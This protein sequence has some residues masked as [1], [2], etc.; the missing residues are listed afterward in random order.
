MKFYV[1]L[2]DTEW[3]ENLRSLQPDEVNFWKP[4]G[5]AFKALEPGAPFLF[6]LRRARYIV[7]GGYFI[8]FTQLPVEITW[9]IFGQKNGLPDYESFRAAIQDYRQWQSN[10][11]PEVGSIVL[12]APFFLDE[13]D[14]I[15][16][17]EDWSSNLVQGKGYDTDDP[18]G[19]A[20]WAMVEARLQRMP[21]QVELEKTDDESS[22]RY[23]IG[24]AKHRLGQ[25]AFRV[26]VTEAY[27]RCCAF[28]NERTLPALVAGHIKPYAKSGPH[29]VRNGVLMRA[30]LHALF[31]QGYMTITEDYIIEVSP[32]IK[33]EYEN[34]RAY[35]ALHGNRIR[36]PEQVSDY[37]D[38][39]YI[40]WH[41]ENVYIP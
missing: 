7:G 10:P 34:G 9:D 35:Y 31:D 18:I 1:G 41:N 2:T 39:K 5:R 26:L 15:P 22:N 27:N 40:R 13:D 29:D 28:T 37:P 25:G 33:E 8:R 20:V 12:S 32:R 36:L 17:P 38:A 11:R 3:F 21:A 23:S 4:S 24:L 19:A 30:D 6:K 16:Q 14:W